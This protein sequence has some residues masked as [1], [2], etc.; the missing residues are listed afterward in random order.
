MMT[1]LLS[2]LI[3]PLLVA[4][5]SLGIGLLLRR[6]AA[7]PDLA[8]VLLLPVGFAGVVVISDYTTQFGVTAELTGPA[9]VA[10]ALAGLVVARRDLPAIVRPARAWL[11]PGLAALLPAGAIAAPVVLTGNAGLTGYG[12][13][14]DI[15]HQLKFTDHIATAGRQVPT[16]IESS[17]LETVFKMTSVGYPGGS[18]AALG[19]TSGLLDLDPVWAYQPLLALFAAVLGLSLYV[20]LGRAISSAPW[21][22]VAAGVAAQPTILYSYAL[23]G[24]IKE[25]AAV[26]ALALVAALLVTHRPSAVRWRQLLPAAVAVAAACAVFNLGIVPWLGMLIALLLGVD[27][28]TRPRRVR[29][30]GRWAALGLMALPLVIP[31]ILVATR[32]APVATQGGPPDMGNLAAPISGWAAVGPWIILDHRYPIEG[33][34]YDTYTYVLIAVVLAFATLGLARTLRRWDV[35]LLSLGVGGAV[36]FLFV[37]DRAGPWGDLKAYSLTAPVTMALAFAGTYALRRGRVGRWLAPAATAV[38]AL[39]VLV[40][41]ALVYHGITL[42]P[43]ERFADLERLGEKYAGEGPAVMNTFDEFAEYLLRD[44]KVAGI[45]NPPGGRYELGPTALP[46]LQFV[47]DPDELARSWLDEHRLLFVRRDPTASRPPSNWRLAERTEFYDVWRRQEGAPQVVTHFPLTGQPGERTR[48]FCREVRDE[49][50]DAG[51]DAWLAYAVAP[52]VVQ[53]TAAEADGPPLWLQGGPD[54]FARGPG[55]LEGTVSLPAPDRYTLWLRGSFGREVRVVVDGEE[56]G[57]LRWQQSYPGQYEIVG[58]ID[59]SA[60]EHTFAIVRGGGSLL[61]GTGNE[62]ADS[63]QTT[64]IGPLAFA[65]SPSEQVKYTPAGELGDV[66]RSETRL[67][68]MEVLLPSSGAPPPR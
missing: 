54:F 24:G 9:I 44:T 21:R 27:L 32:L 41:N 19:G 43:Y 58:D 46:G 40:G 59:L 6:V 52:D 45:V 63:R 68:W 12:R 30:L 37:T 1:F 14:V 48:S 7:L 53:F 10:V 67:D 23:N 5:L 26:A 13:I 51:D 55:T 47:R 62:V 20:L 17:Y 50:R 57:G 34:G 60:G 3:L 65:P 39:S 16:V 11:W 35:G 64:L 28:A 29:T 15:G 61:P 36:A 22:A 49:L 4:V 66:C 42:A 38:V 8:G 33:F 2:W 25:L 18:Q 31:T 56:V